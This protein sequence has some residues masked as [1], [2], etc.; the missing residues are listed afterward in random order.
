MHGNARKWNIGNLLVGVELAGNSDQ[1]EGWKNAP[2]QQLLDSVNER[3]V[4][5]NYPIPPIRAL[6]ASISQVIAEIKRNAPTEEIFF[7]QLDLK[8]GFHCLSVA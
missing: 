1:E 7:S 4:C 3:L 8:N 2:C 5:T 6:N